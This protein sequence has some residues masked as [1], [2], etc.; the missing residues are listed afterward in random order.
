MSNMTYEVKNCI[1]SFDLINT[2]DL[3]DHIGVCNGFDGMTSRYH[4]DVILYNK[5]FVDLYEAL[6]ALCNNNICDI[7][8]KMSKSCYDLYEYIMQSP[9]FLPVLAIL[10]MKAGKPV[11]SYKLLS[12]KHEEELRELLVVL[13][14]ILDEIY[15]EKP[16]INDKILELGHIKEI[17]E[18]DNIDYITAF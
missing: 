6:R 7:R 8:A 13:S 3:H 15:I 2:T 9:V 14:G 11:F 18:S 1:K 16:F 17:F 5:N 4:S 12:G 10:S